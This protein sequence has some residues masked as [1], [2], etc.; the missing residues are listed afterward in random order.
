MKIISL[1][2]KIEVIIIIKLKIYKKIEINFENI[3]NWNKFLI[4]EIDLKNKLLYNLK[5]WD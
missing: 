1:K 5:T 2:I 3:K 4:I